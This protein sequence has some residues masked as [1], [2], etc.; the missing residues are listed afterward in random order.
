M[1]YPYRSK[2]L[3]KLG[4]RSMINAR[5]WSTNIGGTYLEPE[6]VE[7]MTDVAKTF[8]HMGE[9]ID[10][11]CRRVAELCKVDAAYIT[12]GA[13]A[14]ITMATA[15][16]IAGRD[17]AKWRRLPFTEDPPINGR[18]RIIIQASQSAYDI[19]Y[20]AGGGRLVKVGDAVG[21]S[22]KDVE[23]AIDERT[24]GI[25][26][27]YHYNI[28][29]RG[30]VSYDAVAEVAQKHDLPC[31][32]DCAGAFPP[33]SNLH[34]INDMGFDLTIF[35][36]GKGIRGPQ[37][38][39]LILGKGER[40]VELIEEIRKHSSPNMGFGRSFKVS[41]ENIVGLVTALE[42]ALSRDEDTEYE[43]QLAKAEYMAQRLQGIPG[44]YIS[45]VPNDGRTYEHPLMAR[46]PNVR[47]DIDKE[48]LGLSTMRSI[49][50][51]MSG[52]EPG[53]FLR[54][55][56]FEDVEFGPFTSRASVFL[57]TYYLRDG[58]EKIVAERIR[59]VLTTRPWAK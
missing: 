7:A 48:T 20:A 26:A 53:I 10:K 27:G 24:A 35:S 2:A 5:N 18:N 23:V 33:Y 55:P 28:V 37:D 14:G 51:A 39:G 47:I 8:V 57:F 41:K 19:Q 56:R 30:W 38:T 44:V 46:V 21:A 9:L 31:F 12:S 43:K 16:C 3:D 40:G 58:E 59:E 6:V 34:S 11:A 17:E 25:A 52:D 49:Y 4:I 50:D 13:A 15:A 42:L 1:T 22:L 36:G 45:V 54:Q 32:C 29:P